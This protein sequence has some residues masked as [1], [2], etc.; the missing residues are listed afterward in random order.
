MCSELQID[1]NVL[2]E[3]LVVGGNRLLE[4]SG[5]SKLARAH[6]RPPRM[7]TLERS[8]FFFAQRKVG[9]LVVF[10]ARPQ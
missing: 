7:A 2:S 10:G 5:A 8:A 6:R 4:T 1:V 9:H 3:F